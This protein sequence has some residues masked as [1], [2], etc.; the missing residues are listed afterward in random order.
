MEKVDVVWLLWEKGGKIT[1]FRDFDSAVAAYAGAKEE[2][3]WV[4]LVK[5]KANSACI[6]GFND[7]RNYIVVETVDEK[8][9]WKRAFL[10][11]RSR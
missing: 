3:L 10:M 7:Y 5:I 11:E 4:E 2:G 1:I 6:C 8:D 9:I